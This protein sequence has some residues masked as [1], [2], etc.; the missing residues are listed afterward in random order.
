MYG[1]GYPA[2]GD[3][4]LCIGCA[5]VLFFNAQLLPCKPAAGELAAFQATAMWPKV[6]KLQEAIRTLSA[7]ER[8]LRG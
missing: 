2:P 1:P 6:Q 8:H 4:T 3:V 7:I 5:A